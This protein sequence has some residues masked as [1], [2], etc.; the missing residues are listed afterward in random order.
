MLSNAVRARLE[1]LLPSSDGVR[2]R[3]SRD[4]RQVLGGIAFRYRTGRARRDLRCRVD[5]T[6]LLEKG[7]AR[8]GWPGSTPD[9]TGK[10]D[11]CLIGVFLAMPPPSGGR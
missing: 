7:T 6:G 11:N 1:P 8:P 5:E 9:T 10:I 4:D 3:L 2:G